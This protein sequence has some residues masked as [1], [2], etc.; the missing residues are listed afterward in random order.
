MTLLNEALGV[1]LNL[2]DKDHKNM[3]KIPRQLQWKLDIFSPPQFFKSRG[4]LL[5][6]EV[7][8]PPADEQ[9]A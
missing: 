6:T 1:S 9:L 8:L 3:E 2:C 5:R 7:Q 4:L